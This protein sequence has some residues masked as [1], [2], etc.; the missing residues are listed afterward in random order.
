MTDY[1]HDTNTPS[2]ITL[3][4]SSTI[5]SISETSDM[6]ATN[7]RPASDATQGHHKKP[8]TTVSVAGL[9]AKKNCPQQENQNASSGANDK[10]AGDKPRK[11]SETARAKLH[12]AF[13]EVKGMHWRNATKPAAY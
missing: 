3:A 5:P 6:G 12:P 4:V 11:D 8:K 2:S 7:K 13:I 10:H 1:S 9:F